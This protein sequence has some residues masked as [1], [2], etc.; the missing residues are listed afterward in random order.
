MARPTIRDIAQATGVSDAA[1]SFALSGKSGVSEETRQRVVAAAAAVGWH[2]NAAA[3]ALSVAR[4]GAIGLVIARPPTSVDSESFFLRMIAGIESVINAQSLALVLQ[5]AD[6]VETEMQTY[7]RW[8]SERRVDGVV[9][10]DLRVNDP[11]P[12]LLLELGLP[13]VLV[14][15]PGPAGLP[16]VFIDDLAAM[17]V[18]VTHL[19][20]RGHRH[21]AHV[22]GITDFVH[23]QRRIDGFKSATAE[24]GLRAESSY[25]TDYSEQVGAQA[26]E[27]I[28]AL[29]DRPTAIIYDNDVLA[30]AGIGTLNDH[31]LRIPEDV[32]VV[33]WEDNPLWRATRP[34]LSALRRDPSVLGAH[35]AQLLAKVMAGTRPINVAEPTPELIVRASTAG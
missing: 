29:A 24:L 14:G 28:L 16:T 31:G 6:S 11:R 19:A 33:A 26:T 18:I 1:V 8:W 35:S 21:I 25:L 22:A 30:M 3:Q 15:G 13:T 5:I 20:D 2:R 27:E 7:R 12:A 4:A 17:K 10:V 32:A 34:Q 9:L 23:T